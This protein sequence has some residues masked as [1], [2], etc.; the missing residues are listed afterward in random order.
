MNIFEFD[1]NNRMSFDH[2]RSEMCHI[3]KELGD[4]VFIQ[5]INSKN[6][7]DSCWENEWEAEALYLLA[8]MD[9]LS[10]LHCLSKCA[11]YDKYRKYKLKEPLFPGGILMMDKVMPD[12]HIKE[13]TIEDLKNNQLAQYFLKYNIIEGDIRDVI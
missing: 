2:F 8:M 13:K 5:N 12:K 10:D 6:V 11:D 1:Y 4:Y 9:Y 3:L 7:I